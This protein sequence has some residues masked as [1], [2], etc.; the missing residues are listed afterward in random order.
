[1]KREGEGGGVKEEGV[2]EE[3]E[4]GRGRGEAHEWDEGGREEKT[5]E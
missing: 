2:K 3:G 5:K 4:K 1:M